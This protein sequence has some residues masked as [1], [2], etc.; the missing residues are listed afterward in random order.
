[1]APGVHDH[2][3][4]RHDVGDVAAGAEGVI[5]HHNPEEG[6]LLV[7]F[8]PDTEWLLVDVPT[9]AVEGLTG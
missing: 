1:M 3:R 6:S 9:D 7:E 4:L 5:V 8:F 2:V